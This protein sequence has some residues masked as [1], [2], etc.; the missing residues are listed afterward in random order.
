[1]DTK[2]SNKAHGARYRYSTVLFCEPSF[3]KKI[4]K[5]KTENRING[6]IILSGFSAR[7]ANLKKLERIDMPIKVG[8]MIVIKILITVSITFK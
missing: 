6:K 5:M 4:I 8:I 1:M 7:T 3:L 2:L